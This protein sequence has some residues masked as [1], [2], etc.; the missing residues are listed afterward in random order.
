MKPIAIDAGFTCR[1]RHV[2]GVLLD[3]C[4]A[5]YS[6]LACRCVRTSRSMSSSDCLRSALFREVGPEAAA[7]PP[8][9]LARSRSLALTGAHQP[10]GALCRDEDF[11]AEALY[12]RRV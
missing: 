2:A 6:S 11:H 12:R 1:L 7:P 8:L 5:R 3:A 4:N 9:R 10:T